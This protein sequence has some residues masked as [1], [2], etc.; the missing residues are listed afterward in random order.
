VVTGSSYQ[1]GSNLFAY[2]SYNNANAF[3]GFAG[4]TTMTGQG[5]T[6]SGVAAFLSNSTGSSNTASGQAALIN[7]TTGSFN[8]AVGNIALYQ[9]VTGSANTAIGYNAGCGGDCQVGV[10]G[11]YNTYVGYSTGKS[12]TSSLTNATAI[13]AFAEVDASNSLVLGSING[14]NHYGA[15]TYVGIGTTQPQTFLQV[16]HAPPGGGQDLVEITSGGATDVG[17][18]LIQNTSSSGLRLRAGAGT[19]VSYLA[20]SGGLNLVTADTGT[21]SFPSAPA[22]TI[23]TSGNVSI[24]GNLSKGG[25]SFK[26]DHPLDPANK[27]LYHSF[28]ESPD[29]MNIYNGNVVTDRHGLAVVELPSYFEALN[30]DFR[31]QVTVMGQF[32]QAIVVKKVE[33]NRFT[34]RTNKPGVEVSWQ[35][36]GIRQDAYAEAYRI[37]VEEAK[38]PQEQGKYL[39]PELFGA[40]QQL[41]RLKN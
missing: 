24:K 16:N 38:S 14:V 13:G 28:V 17:S 2:G 1:I 5:N 34:I 19:G 37:P 29:M 33:S 32:A 9:V 21:P 12:F 31:Y 22:L 25:G 7:N 35:V 4:N 40:S 15:D 27:Y 3:L 18:L 26:I 39:H 6:A 30:R 23:D 10:D 36:T 11:S 8:T 20:S 41:A